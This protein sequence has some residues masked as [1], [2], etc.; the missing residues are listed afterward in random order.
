MDAN[1]DVDRGKSWIRASVCEP[2]SA[3]LLDK[4]ELA[5][6]I[7]GIKCIL[8]AV[9]YQQVTVLRS[10][11]QTSLKSPESCSPAGGEELGQLSVC[12]WYFWFLWW[13]MLE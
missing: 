3:T 4:M 2:G 10:K 13:E 6:N 11:K 1:P 8:Q 7:D 5:Q 9:R 12:Q